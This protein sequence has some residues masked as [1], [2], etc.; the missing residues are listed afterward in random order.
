MSNV[1]RRDFLSLGSLGI[2]SAIL[3]VSPKA[4]AM[5]Q[6][7]GA[8]D[9]QAA[10]NTN[11]S[12]ELITAEGKPAFRGFVVSDV[13]FG[14]RHPVQPSNVQIAQA[15]GNIRSAI[16]DLDVFI[17]SG[18]IHHTNSYDDGRRDWTKYLQGSI[19]T[20]PL[21]LAGGNHELTGFSSRTDLEVESRT[22]AVG[23]VP[24]R[25]YYS[26]N[27]KG[28]HV[29]CLPQLQMVN[30][31]TKESLEWAKLALDAYPG[32]TAVIITH[33]SL[34]GTT[35]ACDSEVY[36]QVANSEQVHEFLSRYPNVLAWMH[37]HN[38]TWEIVHKNNRLYVSNGRIGGFSP[39]YPG[40]VGKGHLGGMYFEVGPN[41]FTVRGFS[42][43]KECFMDKLKGYE[44]LAK[45]LRV[46]TTFNADAPTSANWGMGSMRS[47]LAVPAYQHFLSEK[48]SDQ[49]L[50][51]KAPS[52]NIFSE[53]SDIAF[54]AEQTK[55]WSKARAIS[56][57][58]IAPKADVDGELDGIR[59]LHPGLEILPLGGMKTSRSVYSPHSGAS[60]TYY[61]C[62]PGRKYTARLTASA[63]ESG[64]AIQPV[65]HV[66]NSKGETIQ[67]LSGASKP[68]D[69]DKR[70]VE[71][72]FEVPATAAKG[73]IF[74]DSSSDHFVNVV[75][76]ARL[77]DLT[78]PAQLYEISL[79]TPSGQTRDVMVKI[80]D[81]AVSCPGALAPNSFRE[82]AVRNPLNK[83]EVI[84][85]TAGG[86]EMATWMLSQENVKW[87][88]RNA[89]ASLRTD[90]TIQVGPM[91]NRYSD[92]HE[93]VI[94]P[95]APLEEN[96][97]YI[98]RMQGID[99]CTIE[100]FNPQTREIRVHIE[101]IIGDPD[102][103]ELQIHNA[104]GGLGLVENVHHRGLDSLGSIVPGTVHLQPKGVGTVVAQ[105]G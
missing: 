94:V 38:H 91:R 26:L 50:Y 39:P 87:Q 45:T 25:P 59:F 84:E 103:L 52:D 74:E 4:L 102:Y 16:P 10:V 54:V 33:N 81:Q 17:D 98:H 40:N 76:E 89:P 88:V 44:H 86:N 104:P 35:S 64:P 29:I 46:K 95:L 27:R 61:R 58:A 20:L 13:H 80:G 77:T 53:N 3:G 57:L 75:L 65:L 96:I 83:R 22:N 69:R 9:A 28:V 99:V 30:L 100:P 7:G 8:N 2:G 18:D 79:H 72:T 36:R 51:I 34:R 41:H 1:N 5:S 63:A 92:L 48:A 14:W 71:F 93:V 31:V 32:Q 6:P 19:G 15:I 42:A 97:P 66:A 37:G 23:S 82:F 12:S 73:T 60:T 49:K 105:F 78:V 21:L 67:V 56:G 68:L 24:C 90:G 47:G 101:K 70:S 85:L 62:V 11:A 55:G 43:T